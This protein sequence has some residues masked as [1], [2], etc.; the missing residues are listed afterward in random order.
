MYIRSVASCALLV[1]LILTC[2][3]SESSG[4][5]PVTGIVTLDGKPCPGLFVLFTPLEGESRT[6]SRGQ[7]DSDGKFELR[8]T[9]QIQGAQ[10]GKHLVQISPNPE[11]EPGVPKVKIPPRYNRASQLNAVVDEAGENDFQ[12]DLTSGKSAN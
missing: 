4:I 7:T 1:F 3:C 5:Q 8:Y 9:S 2:G 12:F 11:P 10:V 6:S